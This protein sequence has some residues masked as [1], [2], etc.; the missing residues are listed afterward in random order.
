MT[1]IKKTV[2]DVCGEELGRTQTHLRVKRGFVEGLKV[3]LHSWGIVDL[4]PVT[5]GWRKRRVDICEPCWDNLK[6]VLENYQNGI[7]TTE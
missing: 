4:S 6:T 3:R 5:S 1:K 7:D 2:C